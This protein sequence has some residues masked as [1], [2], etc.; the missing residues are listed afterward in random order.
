MFLLPNG[1]PGE[2]NHLDAIGVSDALD[3]ALLEHCV[4]LFGPTHLDLSL[5]PE[6]A[7]KKISIIIIIIISTTIRPLPSPLALPLT[8][9]VDGGRTQLI[10]TALD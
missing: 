1:D 6:D 9:N 10:L 5:L 4:E 3:L 2:I 7:W 8:C